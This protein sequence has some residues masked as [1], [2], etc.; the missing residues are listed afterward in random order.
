MIECIFNDRICVAESYDDLLTM[1]IPQDVADAALNQ[2]RIADIRTECRRR[3]YATASAETQMNMAT[4]AAVISGKE[5]SERTS[6]EQAIL[7]GT[8][9]AIEWV[10][11]MRA[12]VVVLAA[13]GTADFHDDAG[14]PELP[15]EVAAVVAQF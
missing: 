13:D 5:S 11:A 9:A 14:W 2:K 6:E 8:R 4:A 7:D 15:P 10:S 12:T 3:I 1:G